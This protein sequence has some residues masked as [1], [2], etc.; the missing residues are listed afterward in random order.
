M[1]GK[2]KLTV[3]SL[4]RKKSS[5]IKIS[6]AGRKHNKK[7]YVIVLNYI[8]KKYGKSK[9]KHW[10]YPKSYSF[11]ITEKGYARYQAV[12]KDSKK[13]Q[14]VPGLQVYMPDFINGKQNAKTQHQTVAAVQSA[15][16][17]TTTDLRQHKK[18]PSKPRFIVLDESCSDAAINWM[19]I[20]LKKQAEK[21]NVK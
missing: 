8:Q 14:R 20:Q 19:T 7:M 18:L 16:L 13:E 5:D 4:R 21:K 3:S 11:L 9:Y 6:S 1:T 10:I 12:L 17:A 2:I 15:R